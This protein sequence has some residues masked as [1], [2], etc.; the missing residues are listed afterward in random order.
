MNKY[1]KTGLIFAFILALILI[2]TYCGL[3]QLK[4]TE[5]PKTVISDNSEQ[6]KNERRSNFVLDSISQVNKRLVI[7]NDSILKLKIKYIKG[8][9][10]VHD[11][12]IYISDS[13]CRKSLNI[14]YFECQKVDSVNNWLILTKNERIKNDSIESYE[15]EKKIIAK[16]KRINRDSTYIEHLHNDSIP[17]VNRR[18]FI[19]GFLIGFGSGAAAKQGVDILSKIK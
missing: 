19:K 9:D 6:I 3:K 4:E 17:K 11:S 14:L 18:G 13:T 8:R 7:L 10:R 2:P 5:T 16:Q 15:K 12:L 1:L